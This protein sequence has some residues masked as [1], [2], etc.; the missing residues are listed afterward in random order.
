M[1]M[2]PARIISVPAAGSQLKPNVVVAT[3]SPAVLRTSRPGH[4]NAKVNGSS[5]RYSLIAG[6]L[7]IEKI[8][9]M[10]PYGA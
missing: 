2:R 3:G 9:M 7:A 5:A 4:A 1:V 8:A 6:M 10:T